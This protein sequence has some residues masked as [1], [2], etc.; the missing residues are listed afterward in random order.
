[1]A[2]SALIALSFGYELAAAARLHCSQQQHNGASEL[3][4]HQI[5]LS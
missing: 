2:A 5:S 4:T 1:M 3:P